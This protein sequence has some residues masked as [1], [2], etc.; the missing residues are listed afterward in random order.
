MFSKL[1]GPKLKNEGKNC[2]P[3]CCK[4]DGPCQWCG[5]EGMCCKIGVNK[6]GCNGI[7]GGEREHRCALKP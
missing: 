6:N 2:W 7:I 5:S 1:L 3:H 4:K